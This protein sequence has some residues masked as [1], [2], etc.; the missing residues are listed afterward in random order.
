MCLTK[1][2]FLMCLLT[3]VSAKTRHTK[4]LT[5]SMG[6]E[7]IEIAAPIKELPQ[8]LEEEPSAENEDAKVA[9]TTTIQA[10]TKKEF[11]KT[12]SDPSKKIKDIDKIDGRRQ[13]DDEARIE[14]ELADIYKDSLVV[15]TGFIN[16]V[17]NPTL[18]ARTGFLCRA[19][20]QLTVRVH[21]H[22]I[23][24]REVTTQISVVSRLDITQ[25]LAASTGLLSHVDATYISVTC[26]GFLRCVDTTC[27]RL[28]IKLELGWLGSSSKENSGELFLPL[29]VYRLPVGNDSAFFSGVFLEVQVNGARGNHSGRWPF[30]VV[31][32]PSATSD[33]SL[34]GTVGSA[35]SCPGRVA[36]VRSSMRCVAVISGVAATW[37]VRE[38]LTPAAQR[39]L[40]YQCELASHQP[41]ARKRLDV[42]EVLWQASDVRRAPV[43]WRDAPHVLGSRSIGT[44]EHR[45]TQAADELIQALHAQTRSNAFSMCRKTATEC[46][47]RKPNCSSRR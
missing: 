23:M 16:W 19:D 3:Y 5:E 21:R 35:V 14:K 40:A 12:P 27:R 47:A 44:C 45:G 24:T 33:G 22:L 1:S 30:S 4:S 41:A 17:E 34:G 38:G 10:A 15:R 43:V 42:Q 36:A 2:I 20:I 28:Y 46:S 18:V 32:T 11:I 39:G 29:L 25:L 8:E 9:T 13:D 37:N 6:Q 31:A 7:V 26:T